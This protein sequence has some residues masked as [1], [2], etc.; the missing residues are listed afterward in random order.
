MA[1][2]KLAAFRL[3]P[4]LIAGMEAVKERTG[5]PVAEQVRRAIRQWLASQG[6]APT[7]ATRKRATARK[8]S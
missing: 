5:A 8:R 6:A 7:T 4:D 1:L 2:K 3:D